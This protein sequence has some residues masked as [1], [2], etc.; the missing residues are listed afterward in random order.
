MPVLDTGS[1]IVIESLD[2]CDFLDEKYP[3]NP[4]YPTDPEAKTRDKTL[5]SKIQ[6][7]HG[8]FFRCISQQENKP[9]DEWLKEFT[10]HLESFENELA[11][12]GSVFFG[13]DKPGM[14]RYFTV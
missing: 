13:G 1:Q 4:L 14:V 3:S 8:V 2:I 11:K 6:P 12:R 7:M 5:L 10:P 9:L